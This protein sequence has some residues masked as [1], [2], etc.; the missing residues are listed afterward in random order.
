MQDYGNLVNSFN[1]Y[2]LYDERKGRILHTRYLNKAQFMEM[3]RFHFNRLRPDLSNSQHQQMLTSLKA[4]RYI[5][6]YLRS[7]N[8]RE[9]GRCYNMSI[10]NFPDERAQEIYLNQLNYVSPAAGQPVGFKMTSWEDATRNAIYVKRVLGK[11]ASFG[12]HYPYFALEYTQEQKAQLEEQ[13]YQYFKT[14]LTS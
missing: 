6:G 7:A 5:Q 14:L 13:T 4:S 9:L 2:L 10:A 8:I 11:I 12:L 3:W 1:D